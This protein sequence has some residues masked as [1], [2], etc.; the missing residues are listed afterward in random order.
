MSS[1]NG[2]RY[3]KEINFIEPEMQLWRREE[4]I[5][6]VQS[7]ERDLSEALSFSIWRAREGSDQSNNGVYLPPHFFGMFIPV[8]PS[9]QQLNMPTESTNGFTQ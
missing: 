2:L 7:I 1:L 8:F 6:Y 9:N 4:N 3:L 5:Q